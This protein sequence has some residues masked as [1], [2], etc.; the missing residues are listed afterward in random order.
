MEGR[1]SAVGIA[2]GY[3]LYDGGLG[4]TVPVGSRIFFTAYIPALG[5]TQTPI[6]REPWPLSPGV[7]RPVRKA[8]HPPPSSADVNNVAAPPPSHMSSW[9]SS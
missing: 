7:K 5:P 4:I 3:W 9:H 1:D 2:T 8:E 6:Q